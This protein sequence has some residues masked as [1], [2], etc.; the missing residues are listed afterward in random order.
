MAKIVIGDP[1]ISNLKWITR[2]PMTLKKTKEIIGYYLEKVKFSP[3][4]DPEIQEITREF[5]K[6]DING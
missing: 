4:I 5:Q 6:K 2:V 1:L 3:E